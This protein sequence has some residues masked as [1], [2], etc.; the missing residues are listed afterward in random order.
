MLVFL[1]ACN[2][3]KV[4]PKIEFSL[5]GNQ[6]PSSEIWNSKVEFCENEKLSAILY[7]D[8][9]WIFNTSKMTY[10][11]KMK[12]DFYGDHQ[13]ITTW[14]TA[15]SGKVDDNSNM[16]YAIGNVVATSDSGTVLKTEE[17]MFR[18]I[19]RKIL[20]DKFVTITSK[21][22]NIQGFGLESDE[23]IKNYKILKP[24]ILTTM[25]DEDKK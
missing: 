16:I 4:I 9:I 1:T 22:E 14:L 10:L 11:K 15:D 3:E 24:V 12:V 19:D 13:N 5:S 21:D 6:T 25:K 17:L 18:R 23:H 8:H 2:Q 7:A 20:S